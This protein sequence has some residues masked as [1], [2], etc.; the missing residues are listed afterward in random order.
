MD[1]TE[2]APNAAASIDEATIQRR[3]SGRPAS[4]R[5]SRIAATTL[6]RLIRM[7]VSSTVTKEIRKP[8]ENPF[9]TLVGVKWKAIS[10]EESAVLERKILAATSTTARP[11]PRPTTIPIA[12][13]TS[14]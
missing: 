13:A 5:R 14:A 4:T 11:T 7:L 1:D 9:A 3:R 6:T 2:A 12:D 8:S 10:K